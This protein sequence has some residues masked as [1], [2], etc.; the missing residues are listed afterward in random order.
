MF[1]TMN[2]S[3]PSLKAVSAKYLHGHSSLTCHLRRLYGGRRV[4]CRSFSSS[5]MCDFLCSVNPR[6]CTLVERRPTKTP[7]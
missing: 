3:M 2:M 1:E 7:S 5:K 4:S 6:L